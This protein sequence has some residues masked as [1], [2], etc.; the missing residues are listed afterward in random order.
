MSKPKPFT[1]RIGSKVEF[2]P[3]KGVPGAE[4]RHGVV[5]DE[6]LGEVQEDTDWGHYI[7][8]AQLIAWNHGGHSVRITYYYWPPNSTRWIFGGQFSIDDEPLVIRDLLQKTLAK[9]WYPPP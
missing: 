1:S 9:D 4:R 2:G 8:T 3:P 7:N 5:K 6:V